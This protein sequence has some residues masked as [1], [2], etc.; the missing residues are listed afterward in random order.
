MVFYTFKMKPQDKFDY[1]QGGE[2]MI[3]IAEKKNKSMLIAQIG[4]PAA[5]L[6]ERVVL[7]LEFP[8]S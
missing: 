6:R 5:E 2:I 4:K 3:T 8:D 1:M 7:K